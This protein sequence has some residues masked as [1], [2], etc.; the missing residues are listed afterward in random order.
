MVIQNEG[1]E[2]LMDEDENYFN[3]DLEPIEVE[4]ED[5]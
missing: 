5:E 3:M 1:N 2:Y 4:Y